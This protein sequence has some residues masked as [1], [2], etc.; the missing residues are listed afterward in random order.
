M[1]EQ[2]GSDEFKSAEVQLFESLGSDILNLTACFDDERRILY[3]LIDSILEE[4]PG[5]DAYGEP[6][7]DQ[8]N[9]VISNFTDVAMEI[10]A[11][12]DLDEAK[13]VITQLWLLD[14]GDRGERFESAMGAEYY[15]FFDFERLYEIVD[16]T[17]KSCENEEEL[18]D[19][20]QFR[21]AK[22]L[23]SD[24]E[25]LLQNVASISNPAFKKI[26]LS[27]D[28]NVEEL[29]HD[30]KLAAVIGLGVAAGGLVLRAFLKKIED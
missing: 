30:A 29:K 8:L 25:N 6:L 26:F 1:S 4:N 21:Y 9:Q 3:G 27:F 28:V 15:D 2:T 5:I 14:D 12:N 22:N 18:R 19:T 17:Y 11:T 24:I 20:L 23:S 7:S 16:L 10:H 13:K